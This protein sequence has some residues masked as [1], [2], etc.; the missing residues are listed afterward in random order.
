[1]AIC[2]LCLHDKTLIKKSHIIPNFMYQGMFDENHSINLVVPEQLVQ[3]KGYI[4]NPS[5]GEYEGGLLCS[6]CDGKLIGGYEDYARKTLYGGHPPAER[7]VVLYYLGTD[8]INFS[9]CSNINY[10]KFKIFL[11]SIL[12]R[13]SISSRPLFNEVQ[14][15][16]HEE[17]IRKMIYEGTPADVGDYPVS[18]VSFIMDKNMPMDI[19]AHPRKIITKEG[20]TTF[21][22]IINGTIYQFYI[23]SPNQKAPTKIIANTISASNEMNI[24]HFPEGT[25]MDYI[26]DYYGL[27]K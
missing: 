15:G 27:R 1:M 22:F 19:I 24:V 9:H 25:A 5:N 10:Q 16:Y 23:T 7:P 21:I 17:T 4:R 11:L 2:K 14:L 8:G 6:D 12:W 3:G 13:A 26:M 20:F 18:M